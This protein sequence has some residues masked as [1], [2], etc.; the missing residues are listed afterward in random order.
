MKAKK[1]IAVILVMLA[2]AYCGIAALLYDASSGV[3][4]LCPTDSYAENWAKRHGAEYALVSDTDAAIAQLHLGTFDYDVKNGGCVIVNCNSISSEI[5]LPAEIDGYPVVGVEETA[6]DGCGGLTAVYVPETVEEFAPLHTEQYVVHCYADS[7]AYA[8]IQLALAEKEA[9][10]ALKASAEAAP[11]AAKEAE[12]EAERC[13]AEAE[14]AEAEAKAAE[15]TDEADELAAAAEEKRALADEAVKN[16]TEKNEEARALAEQLDALEPEVFVVAETTVLHDSDPINFNTADI[17]FSYNK[18]ADGLE[19]TAYTGKAAQI[20]VPASIDGTAVTAISFPVTKN[21][22]SVVIPASIKEINAPLTEARYNMK[23]FVNIALVILGMLIAIWATKIAAKRNRTA[24]QR[25]LGISLIYSGVKYFI[26]L[27]IWSAVALYFGFGLWLQVLIG[28]ILLAAAPIEISM[29]KSA[30]RQVEKTGAEV[31]KNTL[32]IRAYRVKAEELE[33]RAGAALKP[34]C[35]A[36]VEAIRY[37]D[38][39]SDSSLL[40][41]EEQIAARFETF[42]AAVRSGNEQTANALAKE[43]VALLAERN[44]TC[45]LL[46]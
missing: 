3:A 19:V 27:L 7:A 15:G 38:P 2:V 26:L 4:I 42:A 40:A 31:R 39:V 8:Q 41:V 35:K 18:N 1:L 10:E 45:K 33:A 22:K 21:V 37:S 28:V 34:C 36:V 43:L 6:F 32:F 24:E 12:Q 46:K 13:K 17:P 30:A 5:V 25:F 11:A 14:A 29:V 23:F 9:A 44:R 20:V 16:A